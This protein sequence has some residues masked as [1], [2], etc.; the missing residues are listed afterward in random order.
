MRTS[1][2]DP[3]QQQHI[4]IRDVGVSAERRRCVGVVLAAIGRQRLAGR[5]DIADALED[6]ANQIEHPEQS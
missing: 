3:V 4:N 5:C 2:I 6:V 1:V